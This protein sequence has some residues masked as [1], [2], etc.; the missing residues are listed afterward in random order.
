M[1]Y[2][3][4]EKVPLW[5]MA[6]DLVETVYRFTDRLPPE[7]KAGLIASMRRTVVSL[8]A[9][10]AEAYG[11]TETDDAGKS[12]HAVLAGLRE[13]HTQLAIAERLRYIRHMRTLAVRHRMKA[14]AQ[15]T[16]RVLDSFT[17]QQNLLA[18]PPHAPP[19]SPSSLAA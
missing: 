2:T 9:K 3:S 19:Q 5:K 11:A 6:M 10:I 7:E 4:V 14:V 15:R 18:A 13:L 16:E 1:S 17:Q 8:P 12:L